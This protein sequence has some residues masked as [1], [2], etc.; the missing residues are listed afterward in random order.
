MRA[1][2]LAGQASVPGR[3]EHVPLCHPLRHS[4]SGYGI[5]PRTRARRATGTYSG[6]PPTPPA[7]ESCCAWPA[8]LHAAR[9]TM[10]KL[11]AAA[12][13]RYGTCLPG[14]A[15]P[16]ASAMISVVLAPPS[17][18]PPFV[19]RQIHLRRP[20]PHLLGLI[21]DNFVCDRGG[22]TRC[23]ECVELILWKTSRT[24]SISSFPRSR[25]TTMYSKNRACSVGDR[26]LYARI[27]SLSR[28]DG[29]PLK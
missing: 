18:Q 11:S 19:R 13:V 20:R 24:S 10:P 26:L 5:S 9:T 28:K 4:S 17:K 27:S 29:S 14:K 6:T 16:I 25:T 8:D 3:F 12:R 23:R 1:P 22:S 2:V 21:H 15:R 7:C